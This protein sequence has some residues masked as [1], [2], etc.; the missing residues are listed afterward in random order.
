[1]H[2][3]MHSIS[4]VVKSGVLTTLGVKSEVNDPNTSVYLDMQTLYMTVFSAV[5]RMPL[6]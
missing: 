6:I 3:I 2:P 5:Y 4:L 1:M